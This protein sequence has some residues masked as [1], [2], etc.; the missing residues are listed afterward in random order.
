MLNL[1]PLDVYTFRFVFDV[2]INFWLVLKFFVFL[3]NISEKFLFPCLPKH[4]HEMKI[5]SLTQVDIW[6][7]CGVCLTCKLAL[8]PILDSCKS[9]P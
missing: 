1:K 5:C 3:L 8:A 7:W 9:D 4:H 2:C 6:C